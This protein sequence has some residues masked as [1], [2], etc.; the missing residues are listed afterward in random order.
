MPSSPRQATGAAPAP[1]A[2]DDIRTIIELE[3]LARRHETRSERLGR[4]I[5]NVVGTLGFVGLQLAAMAAWTSWNLWGPQGRRFDPYPFGLLTFLVTLE[6]VLIATFV[7]I[8]QNQMSRQSDERDRLNLHVD[9]LAEQ[10]MTLVL[11]MLRE[12]SGTLGI[13]PDERDEGRAARLT[14][15]TNLLTI[16]ETLRE[17]LPGET[18]QS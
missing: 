10:E 16:A 2:Q 11:R 7:L 13:A 3:R 5:S 17:Q 12:I 15:E 6:G 4:L 9:L 8:A 14:E 1:A 18:P